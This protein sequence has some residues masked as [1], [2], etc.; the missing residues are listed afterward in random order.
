MGKAP[1]HMRYVWRELF[2]ESCWIGWILAAET[3]RGGEGRRI[4]QTAA[5][6]DEAIHFDGSLIVFFFP[7]FTKTVLQRAAG[8]EG[9]KATNACGPR[10]MP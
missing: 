2:Q 9:P 6:A 1:E 3:H 8:L 5:R 4:A 10:C 7:D